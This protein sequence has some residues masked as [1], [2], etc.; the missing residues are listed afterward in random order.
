MKYVINS[1]SDSAFSAFI[2]S[3]LF[4]IAAYILFINS[5]IVNVCYRIAISHAGILLHAE[6]ILLR[7]A[8][9]D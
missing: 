7:R 2:A 9:S 3:S 4:L 1:P 8:V 5:A 6:I